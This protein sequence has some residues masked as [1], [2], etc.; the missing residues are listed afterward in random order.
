MDLQSALFIFALA[1]L[2]GLDV[3]RK[4]SPQLHTPLMSLTNAISAISVV[5][6]IV[7]L[8]MNAHSSNS[9]VINILAS[10]AMACAMTNVIGGFMITSRMIKMFKHREG[11]R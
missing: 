7:V 9:T 6:A 4:V 10:V 11:K 1:T 2:A 8:G 5:G 3:I